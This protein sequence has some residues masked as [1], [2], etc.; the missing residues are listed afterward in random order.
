VTLT[1]DNPTTAPGAHG[2]TTLHVTSGV[3]RTGLQVVVPANDRS[4]L[5]VTGADV[6]DV[7]CPLTGGAFVC[8]IDTTAGVSTDID[9]TYTVAAGSAGGFTWT[10]SIAVRQNGVQATRSPAA[11]RVGSPVATITFTATGPADGATMPGDTATMTVT[12][13]N[14]GPS[15]ARPATLLY[16]APAGT[17]FAAPADGRCRLTSDT[18]GVVCQTPLTAGSDLA[19]ALGIQVPA[20]T[21]PASRLTGACAEA[22]TTPSCSPAATA[23]PAVVLGT[24]LS[25]RATVTT[26]AA[27]VTPGRTGTG[28]VI[29]TATTPLSGL[30]LRLPKTLPDGFTLTGVAGPAG[31]RC[32]YS[33]AEIVCTGVDLAGGPTTALSL[34][35]AAA[36]R[37]RAGASWDV[38]G[39]TLSNGDG[40]DAVGAGT[41]ATT[42]TPLDPLSATVTG[43]STS[44]APGAGITLAV[45][46]SNPGPSDAVAQTATVV[47]P[48]QTTFG[49]DLSGAA[50]R[51]CS[52]AGDT[53]LTCTVNLVANG[54]AITW[55]LP[56]TVSAT[57][58]DGSTLTGGCLSLN[59]D[60]DCADAIDV[61]D[62][63]LAVGRP[64]TT[65][66]TIELNPATV[67]PGRTATA[68][69]VVSATSDYDAVTLTIPLP[70]DDGLSVTAATSTAGDC[71]I[72][73]TDI[74][75]AGFALTAGTP[76]T[77]TLTVAA[78]TGTT[79]ASWNPAD[80]TLAADDDADPG[81]ALVAGGLLASTSA[82]DYAVTVSPGP[83]SVPSPAVGQTSVLPLTL[84][85]GGPS[86]A[87]PYTA[88]IV[89]P[90]GLSHGALPD[91]CAEGGTARIIEC[92]V[93]LNAGDQ[94]TIS[95]P[96]VVDPGTAVGTRLTAC[97]DGDGDDAC[98]G[99]D[100][101]LATLTVAASRVDLSIH[102]LNPK[103]RA[104][105]GGRIQVG[106]P[107]VN[108]G[109]TSASGVTFTIDPPAG[110]TVVAAAILLDASA[111]G[112]SAE[113]AAPSADQTV[114][115]ACT[116]DPH[117]DANAVICTGPDAPVGTTS[118]LWLTLAVAKGL[119][120]GT[121]P[122]A[123]TISTTSPEG[124][125]VNNTATATL[126]VAGSSA[127]TPAPSHHPGGTGGGT[128]GA[129]LPKTGA[130][131]AGLV[132]L[133]VM[134][135]AAGIT[136]RVAAR[137]R[138]PV[139]G[140]A[141]PR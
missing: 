66:G 30:T 112:A 87:A 9:V 24:P 92:Q 97:V 43:P 50:L 57:A 84:T 37:L 15:D 124:D 102:Y 17:T 38:S 110:V 129:P 115:A 96:V 91:G 135:V 6:L 122:L 7:A 134:L 106:L 117:G 65:T 29:V 111:S 63:N 125:V 120:T 74:T 2:F 119:A 136:A 132:T 32:D 79:D 123:V 89:L 14:A 3:S 88:T 4:D 42:G 126:T 5:T 13:H 77:V 131:V 118:Q 56:L 62:P 81:H 76:V 100:T 19:V 23:L 127:P 121:Y 46:I 35:V 113:T 90:S 133:S 101:G 16:R 138:R 54:P 78:T 139:E 85:N 68:T 44:V 41:I 45:S 1:A 59:G 73:D 116:P 27:T 93:P 137:R 141:R 130:D 64:I 26:A 40:H 12:A 140:C 31:A 107:Y 108:R 22:T 58:A 114:D 61:V 47:A 39:I 67:T 75:C 95:L 104:V 34:T 49:A 25:A 8:T 33:G 69:V 48:S 109:N 71:T 53:L 98:G 70:V 82:P 28:Q 18:T 20:T 80:V 60:Q 11:A 72:G 10:P 55:V 21:A 105:P 51:D 128:G 99:G 86:D 83:A 103:P 52:R 94:T 36:S